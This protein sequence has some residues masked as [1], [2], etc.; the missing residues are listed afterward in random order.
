M[1]EEKADEMEKPETLLCA[2]C[3]EPVTE[4]NHHLRDDESWSCIEPNWRERAKKAEAELTACYNEIF[5][6]VP[7]A[8]PLIEKI[9]VMHGME[10][11]VLVREAETA[12]KLK[13]VQKE[14]DELKGKKPK[15]KEPKL[16]PI[17]PD[18]GD[19]MS[20]ADFLQYVKGGDFNDDDGCADLATETHVS[21]ISISCS[22]AASFQRPEWAT[23]VVW[24]NK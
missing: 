7:E 17:D 12:K 23:H 5:Y 2:H 16:E 21:D 3:D 8:M 20:W 18:L 11:D 19:H 14:L 22:G 13:A 10:A 6:T 24:Y 15:A 9:K 1:P 4:E